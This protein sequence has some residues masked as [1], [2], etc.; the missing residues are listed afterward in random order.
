[1][2]E[3]IMREN[4][5]ILLIEDNAG[6]AYLIEE[7]LDEFANF[8]FE[9]EISETLDEALRVL[10]KKYFDVILLDLELSDSYGINTFLKVKNENPLIPIIILTGLNDETIRTCAF[11][12]G[13]YEFLFKGQIECRLLECIVHCSNEFNNNLNSIIDRC[14]F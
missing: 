2:G 4:I 1:M 9:L 12:E 10:N 8:S 14:Y 6:D 7:H 5:K 3:R 13:A 11:K